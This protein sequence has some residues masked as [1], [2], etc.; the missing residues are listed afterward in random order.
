[1]LR[2]LADKILNIRT[3]F[4]SLFF[5]NEY[6]SLIG[7]SGKGM[8]TLVTI[9][10]L[11]LLA[12]GTAIGG[13]DYLRIRMDN[14]FTNWVNMPIPP[15]YEKKVVDVRTFFEE[16][17]NRDSF[18][19]QSISDYVA[20]G[21]LFPDA[22]KGERY[23]CKGRTVQPDGALLRKVLG[24]SDGN[25]ISGFEFKS[26]DDKIEDLCGLVVTRRMLERLNYEI[27]GNQRKI[28]LSVDSFTVWFNIISVVEELPN[29]SDFV[30]MPRLYNMLT[31]SF[32]KT[33]FI[34]I[35]G[36]RN[37]LYFIAE[38]TDKA[39]VTERV[40]SVFKN[41]SVNK[42]KHTEIVI[43]DQQKHY[44]YQIIFND[45]FPAEEVAQMQHDLKNGFER[46]DGYLAYT[47]WNCSERMDEIARP[48]HLAFN[49]SELDKVRDFKD[50]MQRPPFEMEISMAQIESKENFSLVSGLTSFISV[51]L[52][53][54]G[55]AS[56]VFF[57]DSLLKTHLQKVKTNLGTFKAFGLDNKLLVNTYLKI[58]I[59]FLGA[60]TLIAFGLAILVAGGEELLTEE[61]RFNLL[62]PWV[63]F[64]IVLLFVISYF[65]SRN[66]IGRIL[67]NTPGDLIYNRV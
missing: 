55:T 20:Y 8:L 6:R 60:A 44:L 32:D 63:L 17:V 35:D 62:N 43:N 2:S 26:P 16:A 22:E 61:S 25:V 56:I 52:F 27:P 9:L 54:F 66:T 50:F 15:S 47:K 23:L 67:K 38:N 40:K 5:R 42:V 24:A 34:D 37:Q 31:F 33:G 49:F 4:Q 59:T 3:D 1:M 19:L 14:P 41:R 65:K 64:A 51:I 46:E 57:V 11:T 48:Y 7:N 53:L 12:L 13:L 45:F 39:Y 28:P 30:S 36:D 18:N 29:L 10:S 21:E 58:I